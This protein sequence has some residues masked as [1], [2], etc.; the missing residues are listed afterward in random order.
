MEKSTNSNT[1]K[2]IFSNAAAAAAAVASTSNS[3]LVSYSTESPNQFNLDQYPN[4]HLQNDYSIR[5]NFLINANQF[6][7]NN[8]TY[9]KGF[10]VTKPNEKVAKPKKVSKSVR[11]GDETVKQAK[12]GSKRNVKQ[13]QTC[14]K[15]S[16]SNQLASTSNG[17]MNNLETS[18]L[19]MNTK[20]GT[21]NSS[22][23]AKQSSRNKKTKGR[24]KIKMEFIENKIR[25]YTTFSKRKTGIMKKAYELSTLTGTQ[26]MLLVASET[27][28]VYTFATEKLK[29]IITSEAGKTLI[30]SCLHNGHLGGNA[31]GSNN[32]NNSNN[33]VFNNSGNTSQSN[34]IMMNSLNESSKISIE[35]F[36]GDFENEF[37]DEEDDF[38]DEDDDEEDDDE[39]EEEEGEEDEYEEGFND[40]VDFENQIMENVNNISSNHSMPLIID[41]CNNNN[42]INDRLNKFYSIYNNNNGNENQHIMNNY[43]VKNELVLN[44][45]KTNKFKKDE[46]RKRK[47]NVA[48]V[49]PAFNVSTKHQYTKSKKNTNVSKTCT[50]TSSKQVSDDFSALAKKPKKAASK[51]IDQLLRDQNEMAINANT[52]GQ[53]ATNILTLFQSSNQNHI[54]LTNGSESSKILINNNYNGLSNHIYYNGKAL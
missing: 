12:L 38:Y 7:Q 5:P 30:Q 20:S 25:R 49:L 9:D 34:E 11:K 24:V 26:V 42:N 6:D 2:H 13:Q 35:N 10:L 53:N 45:L 3:N 54:D 44:E 33:S 8:V 41:N 15:N 21:T 50:N 43:S 4:H 51:K 52:A 22:G 32:L 46:T 36:D 31:S 17:V 47:K 19:L 28:H 27:G 48:Q 23:S 16:K 1:I 37:D 29:P 18:E 40:E 14:K 39:D